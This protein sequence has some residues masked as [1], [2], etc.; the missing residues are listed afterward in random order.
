MHSRR[1]VCGAALLSGLAALATATGL[2]GLAGPAAHAQN[3]AASPA[4][5]ELLAAILAA[6]ARRPL[7]AVPF[8]ERRMSGLA[9][10]PLESRGT[11]TYEPSGRIEKRTTNPIEERVVLTAETI[12][13]S[14]SGGAAPTVIRFATRPELAGYAVALRSVLGGDPKP[15]RAHF[16]VRATGT[17]KK[18]QL[19]L[20]PLDASLKRAIRL[21]QIGGEDGLVRVIETTELSGETDELTLIVK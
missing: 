10:K 2:T 5:D 13:I 18:W 20:L 6:V 15:L 16:Q 4:S 1:A 17:L 7:N 21:V 3:A 8:I 19:S 11:L 9:S 14:G 12:E